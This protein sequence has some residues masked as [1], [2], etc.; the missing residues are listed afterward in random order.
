MRF[1]EL[2]TEMRKMKEAFHRVRY[3]VKDLKSTLKDEKFRVEAYEKVPQEIYDAL[4]EIKDDIKK[5]EP[6]LKD[7]VSSPGKPEDK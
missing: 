5:L 3:F 7:L 1:N 6:D 4:F 2:E